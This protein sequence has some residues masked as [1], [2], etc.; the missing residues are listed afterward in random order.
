MINLGAKKRSQLPP[1]MWH[2]YQPT[3]RCHMYNYLPRH[4]V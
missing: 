3:W 4:I 1:M 2:N